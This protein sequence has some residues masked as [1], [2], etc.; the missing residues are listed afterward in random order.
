[1][2]GEG[3]VQIFTLT[4]SLRAKVGSEHV[5]KLEYRRPGEAEPIETRELSYTVSYRGYYY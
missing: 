4:C 3:G 5:M 2:R 1:M